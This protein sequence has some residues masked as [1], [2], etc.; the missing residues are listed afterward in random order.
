M[1][2]EVSTQYMI[3]AA[4][5]SRVLAARAIGAWAEARAAWQDRFDLRLALD[6]FQEEVLLLSI[7]A[8]TVDAASRE[9]RA[10]CPQ[11]LSAWND[12]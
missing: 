12:H 8:S 1:D 10:F 6:H 7:T 3:C 2:S 11:N 4:G 5:L 9:V